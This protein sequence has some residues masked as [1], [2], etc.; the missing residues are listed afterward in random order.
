VCFAL[1]CALV[2]LT[3]IVRGSETAASEPDAWYPRTRTSEQGSI[4]IH[5]PQIDGW[6]GFG[7]L[8]AWVAFQITLAE[9]SDSYHGSLQFRA[10]TDVDLERR[11]VLLYDPEVLSLSIPGLAED[12]PEYAVVRDGVTA[13]PKKV[14]LDLVLEYLPSD[15][16]LPS[17]E[18]LNPEPPLIFFSTK[19]ALL[20]V[21]DSE[22]MF[23]PVGDSGLE[24]VINTNW[25][26]LRVKGGPLLYLRYGENWL[27]ADAI[28]GPWSWAESLPAESAALPDDPNWAEVRETLPED[29]T[30]LP[31]PGE[32][33]PVVHYATGA[34]ELLLFEGDPVWEPL[35]EAGLAFASNTAQELFYYENR[36]YFL[37]SG[38]WFVA[39]GL[40]GPWSWTTELPSAFLDIPADQAKGH[41][42]S[43]VPGTREAWEAALV[44]SIP[45]KATISRG[46][47]ADAGLSVTYA[48]EPIFRPIEG[49][50]VESAIN[51]SSQVLKYQDRYYVCYEAVW[52]TGTSPTGPWT[53]ADSVPEE[54][55]K[56]PPSA[57]AYNTTHVVIEESD[58]DSITY[59]YTPGYEGAYVVDNTVVYGTGFVPA[60]VTVWAV[61]EIH[62]DYGYG[63]PYYPYYPWPPTY[64][65]GSW[66]D[67][68]TGRYGEAIV[69]YGPY[70]AAGSAAV[71]NPETG[72]YAR[73][74]AV[75]DSDEYAGRG[76][77]YNPNTETGMARNRYF[78]FEDNEGWSEKVV[79]RGDEWLYSRSEWEDGSMH[80]EFETSRG[81]EGDIYSER[82]GDTVTS[83]GS[84]QRG[85]QEITFESERTR[86]GDT[87][88]GETSITG[89]NRS[90]EIR[91]EF[92]DGSGDIS[93]T[94]SEGGSGELT[95]TVEDGQI[96][97]SGSFTKDGKTIDT[98]TTR[99]AEGVR[100]DFESSSG[101]QG[102]VV[103][104]GDE[105]AFIA[106]SGSG[107]VYAGRDGEVYKK[108]DDGWARV[109]NPS[110]AATS[111]AAGARSKA[112]SG[113]ETTSA[114]ARGESRGAS[115]DAR[116]R[117]ASDLRGTHA[118]GAEGRLDRDLRSRQRGFDR[119]RSHQRSSRAF[120]GGMRGRGWRRGR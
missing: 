5:A 23:V 78:D 25:D 50:A 106:E 10:R 115:T 108:T 27:A 48:G 82:E 72:A 54:F 39:P 12:A 101:G 105:R 6:D 71:F 77:A 100:R 59:S 51:T 99:S 64:G 91:S 49:T 7:S 9:S 52:F 15:M 57:P 67:P 81:A 26:V 35:G 47:E 42:R 28:E 2:A 80:T 24:F 37:I 60:A 41:V 55:S 61:Y 79:S 4:V 32:P 53:F 62:D 29:L 17:T 36:V 20:L 34:A 16:S 83:E 104:Q 93:I 40:E 18:G 43:S 11:E 65:Y 113:S 103:R 96:T 31:E 63:Y 33:A 90:A 88:H 112:G 119:Y 14:P 92:E 1:A 97:G 44:A 74:Q 118:A 73:G 58:D 89:E 120:G 19:P 38:R 13:Q 85:D 116:G 56:I 110:A 68:S 30:A 95:R 3:E 84:V 98:E 87:L 76:Y 94:G 109:Q 102:T 22:P 75:W 69:G 70:G 45:R 107:D 114:Q 21:V 46:T 66:Y 86:D 117:G 111:D 8:T